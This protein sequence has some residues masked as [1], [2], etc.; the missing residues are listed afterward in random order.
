MRLIALKIYKSFFWIRFRR[1]KVDKKLFQLDQGLSVGS[2]FPG[3]MRDFK[4]MEFEE[5][6]GIIVIFLSTTCQACI[7]IFTNINMLRERWPNKKVL[8]YIN[9]NEAEIRELKNETQLDIPTFKYEHK[10]SEVYR[11]TIF[12]F[13]YYT[14]NQGVI[15][16]KGPVSYEYQIDNIVSKGLD[17]TLGS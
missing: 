7:E 15:L 16:S 13:I 1:K 2:I 10:Q 11:T 14:S 17:I 8:L 3:A 4:I 9:G 6:E 5:V 12:P